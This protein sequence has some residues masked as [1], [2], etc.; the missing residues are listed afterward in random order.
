MSKIYST[1]LK[2]RGFSLVELMIATTLSLILL[3]AVI[4]VFLSSRQ[5]YELSD[6]LSRI[7]ENG[8]FSLEFLAQNIR[9]AG[10]TTG[11]QDT[12]APVLETACAEFNPCTDD[13][14][15]NRSDRIAVRFD[16]PPN[17]G[18]ETD[19]TGAVVEAND[20]I[21]NV[22]YITT[23]AG[24]GI[25]SLTCRGFNITKN[26]WNA[27]EQPLIDGVDN[28]QILYGLDMGLPTDPEQELPKREERGVSRYVSSEAVGG[29]WGNVTAIRVGL[30]IGSGTSNGSAEKMVR[31]Y[32]LLDSSLISFN[33]EH[34]RQLY[35]TTISL[36][37]SAFN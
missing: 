1:S 29:L 7:Q 4:Q 37:N 35:T 8:R 14:G 2:Q 3:G 18:T 19:C 10:Y 23:N 31:E 16:P 6:D 30:L 28:L 5:T 17:D 13:G 15:A 12:P 36:N 26:Q 11:G 34:V 9:M 20:E 27:P 32:A 22:Y 25:N 33:D 24:T 21:A